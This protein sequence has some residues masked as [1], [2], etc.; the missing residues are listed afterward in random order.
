MPRKSSV[1]VTERV[2][3]KMI[4]NL[5]HFIMIVLLQ[6]QSTIGLLFHAALQA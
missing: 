3:Y 1:S 2:L 4:F 5:V 6:K